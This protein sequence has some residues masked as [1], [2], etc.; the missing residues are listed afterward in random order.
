MFG[1]VSQWFFED[2]GGI[3]AEDAAVGF[4]RIVIRPG[5]FGG[6][7]HAKARYDSI[8]GPRASAIGNSGT[9][10]CG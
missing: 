9:G 5:V 3:R 10:G 8:R 1:S 6:L 2:V 7:T 4:D